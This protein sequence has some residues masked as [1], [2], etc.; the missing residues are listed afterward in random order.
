M[1]NECNK[2]ITKVINIV[3]I[4]KDLTNYLQ[5]FGISLGFPSGNCRL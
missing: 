2:V 1:F 3:Y 4:G 5:V